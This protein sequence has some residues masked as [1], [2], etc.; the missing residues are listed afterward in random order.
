MSMRIEVTKYNPRPDLVDKVNTAMPE[1]I[2]RAK[3]A[4]RYPGQSV[5]IPVCTEPGA[6]VDIVH[7]VN[8]EFFLEYRVM[9]KKR[10]RVRV[11]IAKVE[12]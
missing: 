10:D 8:G 4:E 6:G 9:N 5:D 3:R 12:V 11:C 7:R 1:I 2:Q